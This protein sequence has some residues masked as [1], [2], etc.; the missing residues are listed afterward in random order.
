MPFEMTR[1]TQRLVSLMLVENI[2]LLRRTVLRK[3]R[4]VSS[5]A[6]YSGTV[7]SATCHF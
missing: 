1:T 2:V 7:K 6:G 4:A 5:E 3:I